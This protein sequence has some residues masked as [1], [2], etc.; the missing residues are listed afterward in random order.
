MVGSWNSCWLKVANAVGSNWVLF[1]SCFLN[2]PQNCLGL[3]F[4]ILGR[5]SE[6]STLLLIHCLLNSLNAVAVA[7]WFF[8]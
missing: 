8:P 4:S 7:G 5:C 2:M 6:Y 1:G 3:Y